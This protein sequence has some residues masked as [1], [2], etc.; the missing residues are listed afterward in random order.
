MKSIYKTTILIMLLACTVIACKDK[1]ETPAEED[2][3]LIWTGSVI[4]FEKVDSAD[5]ALEVNQDRITDKVWITRANNQGIFNFKTELSYQGEDVQG[6]SPADTEWAVGSTKNGLDGL[7]FKTWARLHQGAPLDLLNRDLIV[8]LVSENI[9]FD[10][11][12]TSW[13]SGGSGGGFSY[14]RT[15]P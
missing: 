5:W 8:H 15:T 6:R 2:N 11:K 13:S 10:L 1:E 9:Y 7:V 4:S 12:F 14:E 3:Q